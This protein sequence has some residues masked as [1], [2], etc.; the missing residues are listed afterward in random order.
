MSDSSTNQE[1]SLRVYVPVSPLSLFIGT[2]ML[3]IANKML[4]EYLYPNCPNRFSLMSKIVSYLPN[5]STTAS[6]LV[7]GIMGGVLVTIGGTIYNSAQK[8]FRKNNV[9]PKHG[10]KVTTLV[11]SGIF[12]Y[13]RNPYYLS[14]MLLLSG[15]SLISDN[16]LPLILS[17][18][19]WIY[20][21]YY[22][23]PKEEESLN[24]CFGQEYVNYCNKVPRWVK[25]F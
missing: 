13:S 2:F 1:K 12:Q 15:I 7:G 14:G 6:K 21:E 5:L 24:Q 16:C 20:L 10:E 22:V 25:F 18:P 9:N 11:T 3:P 8:E 4:H 23:I 19:W 17:V